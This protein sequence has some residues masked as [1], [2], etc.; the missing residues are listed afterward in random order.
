[1]AQA[2]A[3]ELRDHVP[4]NVHAIERAPLSVLEPANMPAVLIEMGY[5]TN[6]GQEAAMTSMEF[7]TRVA[8]AIFDA[9]FKFR[10]A[11]LVEGGR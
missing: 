5:L 4:I 3:A 9:A 8:Q 10:N 2:L 11:S 7:Q 6:A 1:M